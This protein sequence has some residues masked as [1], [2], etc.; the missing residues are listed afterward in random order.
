MKPCLVKTFSPFI[1][2]VREGALCI[3]LN[4]CLLPLTL[5]GIFSMREARQA[6]VFTRSF[7]HLFFS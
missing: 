4:I 5:K 2:H 3:T 1:Y 7:F 6:F